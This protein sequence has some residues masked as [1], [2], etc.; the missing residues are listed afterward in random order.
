VSSTKRHWTLPDVP[1]LAESGLPGLEV[2]AWYASCVPAAVPKPIAEKLNAAMVKAIN[3][4]E[5]RER[6]VQGAFDPAP[7]TRADLAAF[8]DTEIAKWKKIA[9]TAS[10]SVD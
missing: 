2:T 4:P 3:S 7:G 6:L 9:Q 10:I 1:T 5:V 8:I